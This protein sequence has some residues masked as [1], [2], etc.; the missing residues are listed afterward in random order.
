[1]DRRSFLNGLLGVAAAAATAG[2]VVPQAEATPLDPLRKL[3]A[4]PA[5]S[6]PTDAVGQAPDGTEV[7]EVQYWSSGPRFSSA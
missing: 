7:K 4:L 3:P 2:F 1:M 5:D 6:E